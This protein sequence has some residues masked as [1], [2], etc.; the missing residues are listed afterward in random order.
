ME[1]KFLTVFQKNKKN[2][3]KTKKRV[4]LID[5]LFDVQKEKE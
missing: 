4:E 5:V 1:N 3:R 2:D